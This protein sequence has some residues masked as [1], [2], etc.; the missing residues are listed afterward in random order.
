M[1]A[2]R[3]A[4]RGRVLFTLTAA[5]LLVGGCTTKTTPIRSGGDSAL[6]SV[7]PQLSV[8][9]FLQAVNA[10]D[11]AAMASLFGTA[12]GPV[13][14]KRTEIEL[15]MDTLTKILAHEDYKIVSQAPVAGQEHPT[16]RV[17]VDLTIAG[18]VVPNV[19]FNVVQTKDGN[20][21]VEKI[22]TEAVTN[23]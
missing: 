21:L 10:K 9:R 7:A 22:D 12:D 13:Q 17:G 20:W 2:R 1:I 6:S 15:W 18:E 8:E 14:G 5:M 4:S 3:P 11:Y 19:A 16:T 23:R